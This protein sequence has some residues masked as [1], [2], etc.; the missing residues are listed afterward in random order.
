MTTDS[1]T[2]YPDSSSRWIVF[3]FARWLILPAPERPGRP[4]GRGTHK[5]DKLEYRFPAV[6]DRV[7]WDVW[8]SMHHFPAMAAADEVGLFEALCL[9]RHTTADLA[10]QLGL[11]ARALGILLG[12]LGGLRLAE[13]RDGLW[14]ATLVTRTY[15]HAE[16]QF[17]WHSMLRTFRERMPVYERIVAALKDSDHATRASDA[18]ERGELDLDTAR[19]IAAFMHAHSLPASIGVAQSGD[20][21]GV[22]RLLDVGGGSGVF[23]VAIAQRWPELR[24]TVMDLEAMCAAAQPYIDQGGCRDVVDT[25]AVDMFREPWPTG[26]DALFFSNIYHDWDDRVCAELS[27][28]S[29]AALPRGGRV[30]LHEM[31]MNDNGDG[32]ATTASFSL[33]M[34]LGTRGR[35]YTLGELRGFLERAGFRDVTSTPTCSYYSLVSAI[36]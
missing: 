7:V 2:R 10:A 20:F 27:A 32:P 16:S 14:Q 23:S 4:R 33:L 12:L 26:Y 5:V 29:F 13:R 22:Q 19:H 18:W 21:R 31:L 25:V 30:Y 9:G 15:L 24:A 28:K 3:D 8:L 17:T 34:L 1:T 36:K 6:D 35:Q 11:D